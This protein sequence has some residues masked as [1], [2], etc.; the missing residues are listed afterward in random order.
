MHLHFSEIV[1][2]ILL[3]ATDSKY[4][5]AELA[6]EACIDNGTVDHR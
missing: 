5:H 4:I 6:A 2:D 1:K 3:L